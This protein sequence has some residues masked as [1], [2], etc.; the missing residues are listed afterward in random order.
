[1]GMMS[2]KTITDQTIFRIGLGLAIL[3]FAMGMMFKYRFQITEPVFLENEK[4]AVVQPWE[5]SGGWYASLSLRY[6]SD[7]KD[8]R[9]LVRMEFPEWTEAGIP[10]VFESDEAEIQESG[11]QNGIYTFHTVHGILRGEGE[12]PEGEKVLTRGTAFFQDGSSVETELGIIVLFAH[13]EEERL[14]ERVSSSNGSDGATELVYRMKSGGVVTVKEMHLPP[15]EKE[16]FSFTVNG[17]AVSTASGV[18][19]GSGGRLVIK[20]LW[21]Q[22][23]D[24]EEQMKD[25]KT[26]AV[27]TVSFGGAEQTLLFSASRPIVSERLSCYK[28]WRYL[29]ERGIFR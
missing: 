16:K 12:F 18:E 2:V 28:L 21:E 17:K 8:E 6:I 13:K 19:V 22:P 24:I 5:D 26:T 23:L 15:K 29:R 3:C 9:Q 10:A 25:R 20:G 7:V 1:M 11:S 4:T 27:L 14:A